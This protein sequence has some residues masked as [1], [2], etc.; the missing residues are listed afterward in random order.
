MS[1]WV[2]LTRISSDWVSICSFSLLKKRKG[3]T[4]VY[5]FP[6][7]L[8]AIARRRPATFRASV[9]RK[10]MSKQLFKR[11]FIFG[12]EGSLQMQIIGICEMALFNKQST[13]KFNR[14]WSS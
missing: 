3:Y 8:K 14:P 11:V 7:Y 6:V 4:F 12:D 9:R 1:H 13:K 2:E 5:K 10:R